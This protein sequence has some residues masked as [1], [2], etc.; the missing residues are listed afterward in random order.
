M[1]NITGLSFLS[2]AV[3][4]FSFYN[5]NKQVLKTTFTIAKAIY[6]LI[7]YISKVAQNL[8][9]NNKQALKTLYFQLSSLIVNQA[10]Q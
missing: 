2:K 9:L 3:F 4:F 6:I 8:A 10:T 1:R 5:Y 7:N